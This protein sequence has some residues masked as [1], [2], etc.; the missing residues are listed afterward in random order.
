MMAGATRPMPWLLGLTGHAG[1]G[2]DSVAAVLGSA[3]YRTCA[4]ADALRIEVAEAWHIDPAMLTDRARK[5]L[6]SPALRAA[7]GMR[8]EWLHWCSVQ[9]ISLHEPRSPRWVLQQFASFRR[10]RD[11]LHWV[12]HVL[13]WI[14]QQSRLGAPGVVITDVHYANEAEALRAQGARL[15]R[16]HR[17]GLAGLPAETAQHASEHHTAI[18]VDGDIHNDGTLADLSAEVWRSVS[19]LGT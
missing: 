4:L 9:G 11:A 12:R 3:G 13:V 5:E 8:A 18:E 7:H 19:A 15:L 6:P 14:A 10:D 2:K 1:A 16:V 17:P